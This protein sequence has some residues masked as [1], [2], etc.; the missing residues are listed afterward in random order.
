MFNITLVFSLHV[1][2]NIH[3]YKKDRGG[4]E[5]EGKEGRREGRK[6]EGI[7]WKVKAIPLH[8]RVRESP[9]WGVVMQDC[10]ASIRRQRGES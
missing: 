2:I 1:F 8:L 4:K 10:N 6:G 3:I 9:G 7:G 5:K